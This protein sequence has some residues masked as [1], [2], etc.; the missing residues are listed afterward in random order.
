MIINTEPFKRKI[1]EMIIYA[2]NSL[3]VARRFIISVENRRRWWYD[4]SVGLV[5]TREC[6]YTE[7]TL[8]GFKHQIINKYLDYR[9]RYE[10]Q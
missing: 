3:C 8:F 10:E 2:Y 1:K 9:Q 6:W 7:I 5:V 4:T